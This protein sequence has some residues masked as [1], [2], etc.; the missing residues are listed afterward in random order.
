MTATSP[1]PV[2]SAVP[3]TVVDVD[4]RPPRGLEDFDSESEFTVE[5]RTG[6][7]LVVGEGCAVEGGMR[8]H[9]KAGHG[10]K[11][12]RVWN[13]VQEPDGTLVATAD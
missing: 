4:G 7:H 1:D 11:D 2:V 10:G 5:G 3:Y 12:V 9:E 6:R 8:V 13:I